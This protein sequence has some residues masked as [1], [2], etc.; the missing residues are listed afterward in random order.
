[1]CVCKRRDD[2]LRETEWGEARGQKREGA[3]IQ[4]EVLKMSTWFIVYFYV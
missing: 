1:M 2:R 3:R 4:T